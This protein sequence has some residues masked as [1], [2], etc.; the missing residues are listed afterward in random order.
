MSTTPLLEVTDLAVQ[1]GSGKKAFTAVS[2]G[3]KLPVGLENWKVCAPE[4]NV[5]L[6]P[7]CAVTVPPA[8]VIASVKAVIT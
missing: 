5:K 8:A 4:L 2:D 6:V 7:S 3:P 1:Y